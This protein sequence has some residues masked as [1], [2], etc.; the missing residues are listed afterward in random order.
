MV[1]LNKVTKHNSKRD[2]IIES[3]ETTDYEPIVY[4]D[5]FIAIHN[6]PGGYY[7]YDFVKLQSYFLAGVK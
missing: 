6:T 3:S 5:D 4:A 2:M 7:L 1:D